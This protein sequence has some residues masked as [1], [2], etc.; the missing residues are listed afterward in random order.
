[1]SDEAQRYRFQKHNRDSFIAKY[2]QSIVELNPGAT[3]KEI[4][5][6]LEQM[7]NESD[8]KKVR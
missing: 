3:N 4:K 1:M 5:K 6:I 2:R 8:E 7:W